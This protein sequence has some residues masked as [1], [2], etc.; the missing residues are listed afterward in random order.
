MS[1]TENKQLTNG[2]VNGNDV[3]S[4]GEDDGGGEFILIG[5]KHHQ[6]GTKTRMKHHGGNGGGNGPKGNKL[7]LSSL[8][9]HPSNI[10][11]QQ[12]LLEQQQRDQANGNNN[13]K[14]NGNNNI[15][16]SKDKD[17][18]SVNS[19]TSSHSSSTT[20]PNAT[21]WASVLA[22]SLA[23]AFPSTSS[24]PSA[25]SSTL[26]VASGPTSNSG[27]DASSTTGN[28]NNENEHEHENDLQPELEEIPK[29]KFVE[30]PPP[31]VNPWKTFNAASRLKKTGSVEKESDNKSTASSVRSSS[32]LSATT[33]SSSAGRGT[34]YAS[35]YNAPKSPVISNGDEWPSI[36]QAISAKSGS[37]SNNG[38]N[39][40]VSRSNKST[41][42]PTP[43]DG[44]VCYWSTVPLAQTDETDSNCLLTSK[45]LKDGGSEGEVV[46]PDNTTAEEWPSISQALTKT[47]SL[48]NGNSNSTGSRPQ[49]SHGP[50]PPPQLS[51]AQ[52]KPSTPGKTGR[53]FNSYSNNS[54]STNNQR[55]RVYYFLYRFKTKMA[56]ARTSRTRSW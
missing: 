53:S 38:N 51:T 50:S 18:E 1:D 26:S 24:S 41:Q 37:S 5:K 40:Q 56:S 21:T 3:G 29:P 20:S 39:R 12:Q 6:R 30:A 13:T 4:G 48:Q 7:P 35:A 28:V 55:D 36:K 34:S 11:R 54:N 22:S 16:N 44:M 23:E 49:S 9:Y 52:S 27:D 10:R 47:G 2:T 15:A 32:G 42:A 8:P 45:D 33:T 43:A 25:P 17:S 31:T 19:V 14:V 46:V